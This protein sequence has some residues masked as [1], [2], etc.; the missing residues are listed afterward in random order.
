MSLKLV[1]TLLAVAG[2]VGIAVGYVLRMLIALSKKGTAE[3]YIK[4]VTLKASEEAKKITLKAEEEAA[5]VLKGVRE[6]LKEK[7][8]K[9]KKTEDRLISKEDLLDKRQTDIDKEV[10]AMKQRIQELRDKKEKIDAME[11]QKLEELQKVARLTEDEARQ[12]LIANVEQKAEEDLLVRMKKLEMNGNENLERKAREILT[13]SIQRLAN[14]V[15]PDIFITSVPIQSDELKGK[16]IGK[17]GRNI[18][19]FERE[20]GVEVIIDD[21]PGAITISCFDPVRRA[22]AKLA[23]ESLLLDGRIQPA[24]IEKEVE[25]AKLDI[26]KIIKEKGEQAALECGVFNLDPRIL[27]ILGRLYFR[28]S[29]GQNVLQHSIEMTHIAGMI[30][31]ELGADVAVAK[32][33]ALTHDIGKALDHEVQ[34][35]HVEIGRRILQKFGANEMIV[36]AMEA[37]HEEYPYE[38][39][40]SRIVQA[41]DSISGSRPGARR[42]S[43]ENYIKRLADLEAI[44]NGFKGVDKC[45]ALQAGREIRVFVRPNEI[46][47]LEATNMA[48]D[49]AV[50]IESELKYPGEIRVTVIRENKIVEIAR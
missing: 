18:K 24:K 32:A 23:L 41:A 1:F 10:E 6:E 34:G 21:T 40:E 8:D 35:T 11:N 28:T 42:D 48:R 22:V 16:I 43:V 5:E 7:E 31:Q 13:M 26:N 19:A 25:K 27:A 50:K 36:K 47:D 29:Y 37:H 12:R 44:A 4:E 2:I 20:T 17:E 49:I 14:S 46:S 45:Y 9:I 3:H 15:S 39:L 33:G 38:T 30:A